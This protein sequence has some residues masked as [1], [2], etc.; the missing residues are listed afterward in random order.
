M[1]NN[2][3]NAIFPIIT[4]DLA[5]RISKE[6][7]L[8]EDETIE[9]LYATQLYEQ[10]ENEESKVWQYST[11][12]LYELYKSEKQTGKLELSEY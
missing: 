5:D 7:N 2:K 8:S 12:K 4:A 1:D 10:L 3:F 11:E 9:Q 6:D